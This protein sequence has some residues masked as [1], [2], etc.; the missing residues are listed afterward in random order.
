MSVRVFTEGD[1]ADEAELRS[2]L[3]WLQQETPRPGRVELVVGKPQP[4]AMG[5]LAE[6]LEVA[7]QGGGAVTVLA[8]SVATWMRTRRRP[9]RLRLRRSDGEEIVIEA[10][11]KDPEA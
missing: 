9:V 10:E 3:D 11:V 7:L 2:L 6:A 8:G 4:G 5:P 1:S